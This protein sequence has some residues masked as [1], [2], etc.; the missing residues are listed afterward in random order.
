LL[1]SY[2]NF[3]VQK[4]FLQIVGEKIHDH[5][6]GKPRIN[7]ASPSTGVHN[8]T[9]SYTASFW[10]YLNSNTIPPAKE[11]HYRYI[12]HSGNMPDQN[13]ANLSRGMVWPTSGFSI[14]LDSK[15]QMI[16]TVFYEPSGSSP[17]HAQS[18][19][20]IQPKRWTFLTM[21]VTDGIDLNLYIDGSI[22]ITHK[23][24]MPLPALT[25][26]PLYVGTLPA[27]MLKLYRNQNRVPSAE[28]PIV[29]DPYRLGIGFAG[30]V[31]DMRLYSYDVDPATFVPAFQER[32][33]KFEK[34][35]GNK[36]NF[37]VSVDKP[38]L[39]TRREIQEVLAASA[40]GPT[41]AKTPSYSLTASSSS[42]SSAATIH[43]TRDM[44]QQV[45]EVF[46]G[47]V[48]A[49][50]NKRPQEQPDDEDE[51]QPRPIRESFVHLLDLPLSSKAVLAAFK[52][53]KLLQSANL[54]THIPH[55]VL[56]Q[57]FATIQLLNA[58]LIDVLP[59]VDCQ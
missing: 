3:F 22:E 15:S 35:R 42:G 25:T 5:T 39:A 27:G 11:A 43:F 41:P 52:D 29:E 30:A 7:K 56:K 38:V 1:E 36:N 4:H 21:I 58:K 59:F 6:P 31:K 54:L 16:H 45:I 47:I 44:D 51:D 55:D 34:E 28:N 24:Q 10:L 57:R 2:R 46:Q 19:S 18:R 53:P 9:R 48:T 17:I 49:I 20:V 50:R 26:D 32:A 13:T 12:L 40:S 37:H 23:F 33:K 8:G 14:G